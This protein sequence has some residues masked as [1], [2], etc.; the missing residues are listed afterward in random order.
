MATNKPAAPQPQEGPPARVVP[1]RDPRNDVGILIAE[2]NGWIV[3]IRRAQVA[4]NTYN[5]AYLSVTGQL[6]PGERKKGLPLLGGTGVLEGKD[7]REPVNFTSDLKKI[8]KKYLPHVLV[9]LIGL[10]AGELLEAV[11]EIQARA[12]ALAPILAALASSAQP[13]DQGQA[14]A[15]DED[16]EEDED[17]DDGSQ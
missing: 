10:H 7:N 5:M 16:A 12:N 6:P 8:N 4:F 3:E 14:D 1:K 17:E 2:L 13:A 15:E 9:P 11:T